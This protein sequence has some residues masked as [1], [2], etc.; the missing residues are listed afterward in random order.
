MV[1]V[2]VVVACQA[3]VIAVFI[4]CEADCGDIALKGDFR[5]EFFRFGKKAVE[6]DG[7]AFLRFQ[8]AKEVQL[9]LEGNDIVGTFSRG[10]WD[11]SDFFRRG[12]SVEVPRGEIQRVSKNAF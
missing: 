5:K 8:I 10:C 7:V 12:A 9:L 1:L 3:E 6:R 11:L 2:F 4:Y